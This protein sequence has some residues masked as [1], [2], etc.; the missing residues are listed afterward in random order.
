MVLALVT[1]FL[2]MLLDHQHFV[3]RDVRYTLSLRNKEGSNVYHLSLE[4]GDED[5]GDGTLKLVP[6]VLESV[7]R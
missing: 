7:H 3:I 2:I 4:F 1:T 6:R 5:E